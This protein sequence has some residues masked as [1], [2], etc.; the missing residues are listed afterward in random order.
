[1]HMNIIVYSI[2][3]CIYCDKAKELL[4]SKNLVYEERDARVNIGMLREQIPTSEKLTAPQIFVDGVR[5]GGY[6]ELYEQIDEITRLN[7]LV[8]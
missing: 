5:I 3:N 4:K 6:T 7:K 8:I 1:M 2:D